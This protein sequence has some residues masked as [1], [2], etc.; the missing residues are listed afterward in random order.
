MRLEQRV[1]RVDRIGQTRTVHAFHLVGADTGELGLLDDLRRRIAHAQIDIGAPDPLDGALSGDESS[2]MPSDCADVTAEVLRLRLRRALPSPSA[3]DD[4]R[5]L[6]ARARNRRTRVRLGPRRLSLWES[7]V[8]DGAGRRVS[9]SLALTMPDGDRPMSDPIAS[10]ARTFAGVAIERADA[11]TRSIERDGGVSMQPGLF[12]RR[13]H[14]AHSAMKA[15]HDE[16]LR[17]QHARRARL[18]TNG[19]L[20]ERPPR[21]R[22][23]L[24][25]A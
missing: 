18:L 17:S 8:E 4:A 1:G 5:P 16:A 13:A 6:I 22:L 24:E 15:A 25:P 21:L 11:V 3:S 20:T 12:D 14:F 23:V 9:S 7:T 19:E 2:T 10:A